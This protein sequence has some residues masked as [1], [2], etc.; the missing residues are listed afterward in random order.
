MI[1][2][3]VDLFLFGA[4]MMAGGLIIVAGMVVAFLIPA[5]IVCW[6]LSL[7][8]NLSRPGSDV[9]PAKSEVTE[10]KGDSA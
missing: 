8:G 7:V 1:N 2:M 9:A 10:T 3:A 4:E 6:I 5:S